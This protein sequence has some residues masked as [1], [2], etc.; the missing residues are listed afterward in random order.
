MP[1]SRPIRSAITVAGIVGA[2]FNSSRICG[3]TGSTTEPFGGRE[4]P[5]GL[6]GGQG[7]LHGVS[8]DA[9]LPG[10]LRDRH[11]LGPVEPADLCP[12]RHGGHLLLLTFHQDQVG[13]KT[14]K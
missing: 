9:Q 3:S 2:S 4:W 6:V 8:R 12:V 1:Q 14:M 11:L 7:P 5:G 13:Q 10:S